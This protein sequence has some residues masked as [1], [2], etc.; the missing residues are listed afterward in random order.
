MGF[1][2][3]LKKLEK[4]VEELHSEKLS[5]EKSIE[6]FEDGVKLADTCIKSL[7]SM[8]KKIEVISKAKDGKIKIM[9]FEEKE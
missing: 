2:E 5:L 7:D 4:I 6:K 1:E 8:K 3:N 9:P